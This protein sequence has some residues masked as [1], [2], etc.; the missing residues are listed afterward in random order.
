MGAIPRGLR[1]KWCTA[2][3]ELHPIAAFRR[4]RSNAD[5]LDSV[6][7]KT[8]AAERRAQ[9]AAS[10][11]RDRLKNNLRSFYG[12]SLEDY[13]R[14]RQQQNYR[15]AIC[16]LHEDQ[17]PVHGRYT[18][19]A[20]AHRLQVD[21]C[22][23]TNFIRGLLCGACNKMLAYAKDDPGVLRRGIEYLRTVALKQLD[24]LQRSR[25]A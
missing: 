17:S 23:K 8:Q 11:E 7:R 21:H 25:S 24:E 20:L 14:L 16:G 13:D 6:C 9:Y 1:K 5:G 18:K 15:C 22:H 2:C 12:L 19:T 4:Q 3:Q 10:S